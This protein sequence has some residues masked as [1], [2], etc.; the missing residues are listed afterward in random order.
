M[1]LSDYLKSNSRKEL[2]EKLSLS[3]ARLSHLCSGFR[4][5]SPQLSISIEKATDGLVTRK[6]LRPN[7]WQDIWPELAASPPE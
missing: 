5:P 1:N 6:D 4:K 7:D 3:S 2:A